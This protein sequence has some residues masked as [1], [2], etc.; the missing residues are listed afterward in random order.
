MDEVI[1]VLRLQIRV[2]CGTGFFFNSAPQIIVTWVQVWAI[3]GLLLAGPEVPD[4]PQQDGRRLT[5]E[6]KE[7]A[8]LLIP[9]GL[10]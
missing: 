7:V 1:A 8:C 4:L 10:L 5:S 6:T 9:Y 2:A 3:G